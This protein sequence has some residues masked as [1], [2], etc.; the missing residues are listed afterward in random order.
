MD[1]IFPDLLA[2]TLLQPGL[3][4]AAQPF[5]ADGRVI[6]RRRLLQQI[7]TPIADALV[8]T[9]IVV[10]INVFTDQISRIMFIFLL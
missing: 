10:V 1:Q 4:Q 3:Q 7:D 2:L 8:R 6:P 9:L 5:A